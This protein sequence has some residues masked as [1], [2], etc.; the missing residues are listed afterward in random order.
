ML[1]F[2]W[3]AGSFVQVGK[4]GD[5]DPPAF[6]FN[7]HDAVN[8]RHVGQ[9]SNDSD[10]NDHGVQSDQAT[11]RK[12]LTDS[13]PSSSSHRNADG[14]MVKG[15]KFDFDAIAKKVGSLESTLSHELKANERLLKVLR[16]IQRLSRQQG[17][18]VADILA[19]RQLLESITEPSKYLV[20]LIN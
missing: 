2:Q 5:G 11:G 1:P 17:K 13:D 16:N 14:S 19:D 9:A 12:Q 20:S 18:S 6:W 8:R 4:T 15:G 7:V 3:L 10:G